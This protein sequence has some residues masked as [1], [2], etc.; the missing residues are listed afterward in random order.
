MAPTAKR[1]CGALAAAQQESL[2]RHPCCRGAGGST[3]LVF[4]PKSTRWGLLHAR[5]LGPARVTVGFWR[6]N[7][8]GVG[9]PSL[10][11]TPTTSHTRLP[12]RA[13]YDRPREPS[14]IRG[15]LEVQGEAHA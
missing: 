13:R 2:E 15:P 14:P 3:L 10:R 7:P 11:K 8:M 12:G 6:F 4:I 9:K 5:P 1:A